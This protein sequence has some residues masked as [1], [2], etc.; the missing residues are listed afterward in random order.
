[1]SKQNFL[2]IDK[3]FIKFVSKVKNRN[4]KNL[5]KVKEKYVKEEL[6]KIFEDI[7]ETISILNINLD[8]LFD[9]YL[10]KKK[11]IELKQF[12]KDW[13]TTVLCEIVDKKN[14]AKVIFNFIKKQIPIRSTMNF[15]EDYLNFL[16]S[17]IFEKDKK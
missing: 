3:F 14:K 4:R 12:L 10:R 5:Y 2:T 16:K 1:M 13:K 9:L 8:Q 11:D 7:K 15:P 6:Q 17:E